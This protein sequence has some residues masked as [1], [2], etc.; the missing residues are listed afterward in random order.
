MTVSSLA[1]VPAHNEAPSIA[2]VVEEILAA[3]PDLHIV[4]DDDG[5]TYG[6][7][8]YPPTALFVLR[9]LFILIVL[10]NTRP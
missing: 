6:T 9:S 5:S 1:I 10:L 3:D 7:A 8:G 4:V 2:G